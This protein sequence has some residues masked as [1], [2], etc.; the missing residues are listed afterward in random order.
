MELAWIGIPLRTPSSESVLEREEVNQGEAAV[1][2]GVAGVKRVLRCP[3]AQ[4]HK[5]DAAIGCD[6]TW[7]D[8]RRTCP[9]I[10]RGW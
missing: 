8:A 9:H 10:G 3:E 5:A 4:K 7:V 2:D 6:S 1:G